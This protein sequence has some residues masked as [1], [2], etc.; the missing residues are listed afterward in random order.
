MELKASCNLHKMHPHHLCPIAVAR[1]GTQKTF[2]KILKRSY[3]A[4]HS[5]ILILHLLVNTINSSNTSCSLDEILL[6]F[7]VLAN[8]VPCPFTQ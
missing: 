1:P 4:L 2:H 8:Q 3:G 7:L 6:T 5:K